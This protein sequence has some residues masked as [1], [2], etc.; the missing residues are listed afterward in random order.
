MVHTPLLPVRSTQ[1]LLL[2][3]HRAHRIVVI[4]MKQGQTVGVEVFERHMGSD[5]NQAA[6]ATCYSIGASWASSNKT[7]QE[8][9]P[10]LTCSE[11]L[12][13]EKAPF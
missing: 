7:R 9:S 6:L 4:F 10:P 12:C 13:L 8:V 1:P 3:S 2:E 5:T 11:D